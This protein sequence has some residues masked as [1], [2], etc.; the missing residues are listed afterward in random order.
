L[1]LALITDLHYGIRNDSPIF[2]NYQ[3]KSNQLFFETLRNRGITDI[4][5]LGD[6]YD[7]KKYVNYVTASRARTDFLDIVDARFN[8]SIIAGNHDIYH[9][10][11][12]E[13]NALKELVHG[14]YTNIECIFELKSKFY[15]STEILLLP[16]I[17]DANY[18]ATL[19]VINKTTAQICFGHLELDG[20]EMDK[21]VINHGGMASNMFDRFDLVCSGHFHHKS[22][23]GNINYLGAAYEFTWADWNDPRGF[24]IFDTDTRELE[25]IKNPYNMFNMIAYDDENNLNELQN[26]VKNG[27]FSKYKDTYVRIV[28]L[29]KTNPYLFDQFLDK[30]YKAGPQDITVVEDASLFVEESETEMVNQG[31]DT[32]TILN[33]YIDGLKMDTDAPRVKEMMKSI[34]MEAIALKE[35]HDQ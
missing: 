26:D 19:Q 20:F 30:L 5:C 27:D 34:Y 9:K 11:H 25:F 35:T 32:I 33:K 22:S 7:R 12:S 10:N 29:K 18:D 23:R 13:I 2:Y 4:I 24:T 16:W 1:K 28:S 3:E 21:G 31:E 6:L 8:M 15:D 17:N 14:R